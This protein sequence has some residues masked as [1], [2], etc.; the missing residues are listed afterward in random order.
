MKRRSQ[1][2]AR[3][4]ASRWRC[5]WKPTSTCWCSETFYNLD[6]LREAIFAA[7]EVAGPEMVIIAQVTFDDYGNLRGGADAETFTRRLDEWPV[8]VIGAN[9]SVGP[10]VMLET[11]ERM[12]GYSNK[13]MS[14]M[15]NA[16]MPQRVEGRHIYL[17]S[18][19]Y[20]SQYARRLLWAGVKIVGGCCGTT[21]EHIKLIRS[22]SAFAAAWPCASAGG[23]RGRSGQTDPEDEE[24]SGCREVAIGGQAGGG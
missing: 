16:G 4:F 18:P 6:E 10:K 9:C 12:M 3:S 22:G 19:E 20:M 14:A 15:P 23:A 8:D 2:C 24:G 13:P 17:C 5:W 11:M 1:K 21:P 7:R